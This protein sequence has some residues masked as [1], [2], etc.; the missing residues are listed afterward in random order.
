M[1]LKDGFIGSRTIIVPQMIVKMMETDPLVSELF[2]TDI[3]YYPH[4]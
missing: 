2:V 3:G 4:A 1:K